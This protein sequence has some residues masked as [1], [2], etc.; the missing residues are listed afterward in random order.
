MGIGFAIPINKAKEIKDRLA[1]GQTIAH[2][3]IGVQIA[4]LTPEL[5]RRNN[6]DIKLRL[7]PAGS[8]WSVDNSECW[9]VPPLL[10]LACV[11]AM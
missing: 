8:Q 11:E 4:D 7:L 10:M 2:P 3:Y 5:A 6:E 9:K 1:Q